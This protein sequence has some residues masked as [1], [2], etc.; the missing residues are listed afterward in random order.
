[1][2]EMQLEALNAFMEHGN[3]CTNN[4]QGPECSLLPLTALRRLLAWAQGQ[5]LVQLPGLDSESYV[6]R[7]L[8]G[9]TMRSNGFPT[10]L[11][12]SFPSHLCLSYALALPVPG[13]APH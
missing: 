5:L 11:L 3:H 10:S 12:L 1:M 4:Y 8:Q 2:F 13:H 9:K 6:G 7:A